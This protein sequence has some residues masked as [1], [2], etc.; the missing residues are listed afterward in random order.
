[1]YEFAD[2]ILESR[3]SNGCS[4]REAVNDQEFIH[5]IFENNK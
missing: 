4:F 2:S 5:T 1:L 3:K